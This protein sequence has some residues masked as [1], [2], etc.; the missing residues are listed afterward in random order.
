MIYDK[1][2]QAAFF[3]SSECCGQYLKDR[4]INLE[5]VIENRIELKPSIGEE[6]V[7]AS[8]YHRIL[9]FD[10]WHTG[11]LHEQIRESI[12][13]PCRDAHGTTQSW[14]LRPFPEL[15]GKNGDS[16]TKFLTPRDGNNYPFV[17]S[18][19]W[20]VA[21]NPKHPLLVTEGPCK[22]LAVL[23]G[24]AFP[25]AVNGVWMA[26]K[27]NQFGSTELHPAFS[28]F[29]LRGRTVY[30]VFDADFANNPSVRQALIR[31]AVLL[32][33][34]GAEVKILTWSSTDGKGIDDLMVNSTQSHTPAQVLEGL[35]GNACDLSGVIRPCD[36]ES[37]EFEISRA[38]LKGTKLHQFC[39][40]V[41]PAL[42]LSADLLRDAVMAEYEDENVTADEEPWPDTVDGAALADDL[43]QIVTKHVILGDTQAKAIALW[44]F[45]TYVEDIVNVLPMLAIL[46]PVKRCGKT[47]LLSLLL[48][49]V[50]KPLPASNCSTASLYR[51]IE[52]M[53]P[54]LLVDE[55]DAWLKD[56]EEARG[57]LNSGHARDLAFVLR[58]NADSSE[59]ERFST[60]APKVLAGIGHL[61]E[62]L[63]DRSIVI[64]LQRRKRNQKITK[65]RDTDPREFIQL[66]QKLV[67]WAADNREDLRDGHP[68][69]PDALNDREGDNWHSLLSIAEALSGKW[70]Q[71]AQQIALSLSD[72]DDSEAINTLVL[73]KLKE[74]I[75]L[76]PKDQD[77]IP[78]SYFISEVNRDKSLPWADWA[79]GNGLTE[80]KL[81]L[82]LKDFGI[83]SERKWYPEKEEK[84]MG[85]TRTSLQ[86]VFERYVS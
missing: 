22:G 49:L 42:K 33:K 48:R 45:L 27:T 12:W 85:Y 14:I 29:K 52:K 36:L 40:L 72:S 7:L 1:E 47:T 34:E 38:R 46:S 8:T 65:L 4:G 81:A 82:I 74:A 55:V 23:Q 67:R 75:D 70:Q 77:H 60:W 39:R 32:H 9:G 54:T 5:T 62:T 73:S 64:T 18:R 63:T 76:V 71:S 21:Q 61:A 20:K 58:C 78:T 28:E 41:A 6:R 15:T 86:P 3:E 35:Y 24:G 84:I 66:R 19:T 43:V 56:N 44:V 2:A 50:S 10:N 53:K 83:K 13:F 79:H 16:P 17:P 51:V 11:P 26:A 59:P 31:T 25:I 80:K 37:M 30:V 57:I 68:I 69:I